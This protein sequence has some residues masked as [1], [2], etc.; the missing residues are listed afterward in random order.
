MIQPTDN[1]NVCPRCGKQGQKVKA[2]TINHLVIEALTSSVNDQDYFLCMSEDCDVAYYNDMQI[3]NISQLNVPLWFKKDADPKYACYCSKVTEAQV[4][5]AIVNKGALTMSDVLRITGAMKHAQCQ[6]NN[7][8]G[9]CCH[10]IVQDAMKK[11]FLL[12][13]KKQT[14]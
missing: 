9:V 6:N 12:K 4:I 14:T 5:D 3:F 8:L 7:P 10:L 13:T 1:Q 2:I 11:G